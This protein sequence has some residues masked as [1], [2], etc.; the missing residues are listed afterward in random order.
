MSGKEEEEETKRPFP[1]HQFECFQLQFSDGLSM[2]EVLAEEFRFSLEPVTKGRKGC[3]ATTIEEIDGS[4]P[5]VKAALV[6][7]TT[8]YQG[9][10]IRFTPG[11]NRIIEELERLAGLPFRF[12]NALVEEY[13]EQYKSMKFHSDQD[14]D[15]QDGTFIALFSCYRDPIGKPPTRYLEVKHKETQAMFTVPLEHHS[16]VVFDVDWTNKTFQHRIV[17]KQQDGSKQPVWM[18]V[19]FRQS[20]T[21]LDYYKREEDDDNTS[22]GVY[23]HGTSHQLHLAGESEVKDWFCLR[24]KEN[25]AKSKDEFSYDPAIDYTISPGDLLIPLV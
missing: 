11:L 5:Y 23:F 12:N 25:Q 15:L 1:L 22:F 2:F 13:T 4:D 17:Y 6:R 10:A 16:V 3:T 20:K 18:G 14:V 21:F 19:T 7:S 8:R 24:N 9:P